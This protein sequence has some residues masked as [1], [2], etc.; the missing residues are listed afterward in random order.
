MSSVGKKRL[1]FYRKTFNENKEIDW[2]SIEKQVSDFIQCI[3]SNVVR[4]SVIKKIEAVPW[5]LKRKDSDYIAS[6]IV[7]E[8]KEILLKTKI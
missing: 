5:S 8:L 3:V 6:H 4:R 7:S 2:E 1:V